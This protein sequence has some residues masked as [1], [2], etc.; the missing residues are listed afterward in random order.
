MRLSHKEILRFPG[1]ALSC[2]I[3]VWGEFRG[4]AS[5]HAVSTLKQVDGEVYVMRNR[6]DEGWS[7]YCAAC[8]FF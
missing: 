3:P 4:G 7:V 8:F 2:K 5:S 6:G 1:A